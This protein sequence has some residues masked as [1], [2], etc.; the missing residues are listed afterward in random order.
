M[1]V[2]AVAATVLLETNIPL[3]SLNLLCHEDDANGGGFAVIVA[4]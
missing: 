4:L 1:L 3:L 2:A